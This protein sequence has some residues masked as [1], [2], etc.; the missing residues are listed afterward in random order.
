MITVYDCQQIV[1]KW[2]ERAQ[3][4][5]HSFDYKNALSECINE[6]NQLI[7]HSIEEE[8]SYQDYLDM[9]ADSYLSAMKNYEETA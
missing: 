2:T 7:S 8:L 1:N 5:L 3:N 6:L 4:P 9:E